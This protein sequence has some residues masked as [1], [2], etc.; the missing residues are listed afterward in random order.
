MYTHPCKLLMQADNICMEWMKIFYIHLHNW[1]ITHKTRRWNFEEPL[2]NT[3]ELR[4]QEQIVARKSSISNSSEEEAGRKVLARAT[5]QRGTTKLFN[6]KSF[7][8][9]RTPPQLAYP[10]RKLAP[11]GIINWIAREQRS[12]ASPIYIYYFQFPAPK[13]R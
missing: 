1:I 7:V 12:F 8:A 9:P 13:N 3:C 2:C 11:C 10:S 4:L 5:L 6:K